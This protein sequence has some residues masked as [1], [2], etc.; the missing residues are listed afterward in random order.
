MVP[1]LSKEIINNETAAAVAHEDDS[2]FFISSCLDIDSHS[3][4]HDASTLR[5]VRLTCKCKSYKKYQTF[6]SLL[7]SLINN[8]SC[9]KQAYLQLLLGILIKP[10]RSNPLP[11]DTNQRLCRS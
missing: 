11:T 8:S 5:S 3:I 1:D 6:W 9:R 2:S 10:P 4:S 7:V